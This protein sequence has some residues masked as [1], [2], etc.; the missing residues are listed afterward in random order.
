MHT[1]YFDMSQPLRFL[2]PMIK[3]IEW[4]NRLLK[5]AFRYWNKHTGFSTLLFEWVGG[6]FQDVRPQNRNDLEK[7]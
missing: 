5:S 1:Q 4:C 2:V 3:Q 6:G 7:K